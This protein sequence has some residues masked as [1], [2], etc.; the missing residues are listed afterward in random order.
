GHPRPHHNTHIKGKTQANMI[1]E[2]RRMDQRQ[3]AAD[4]DVQRCFLPARGPTNELPQSPPHPRPGYAAGAFEPLWRAD[5][6]WCGLLRGRDDL[7]HR[8][9]SIDSRAWCAQAGNREGASASLAEEL[10]LVAHE[11][12][13][14]RGARCHMRRRRVG[15]CQAWYS[16]SP[17]G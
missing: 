16:T 9:F 17:R 3:R 12:G 11:R 2:K 14:T 5:L 1:P 7:E 8:S 6:E 15:H 13:S 4:L 10:L